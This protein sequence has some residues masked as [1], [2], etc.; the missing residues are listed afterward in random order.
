MGRV[1]VRPLATLVVAAAVS[2]AALGLVADP[3]QSRVLLVAGLYLTFVLS[4][5]VA[6]FVPTLFLLAAAPLLLGPLSPRYTLGHVLG[7]AVDP[8]LALFAGG[9][10]LGLAAERH[11]VDAALAALLLRAAGRTRRGLLGVTLAAATFLSMWMSNV[12]A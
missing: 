4:E 8:V 12:A 7:W 6:P 9:L 11:G 10:A 2:T 3:L 1:A 5:T